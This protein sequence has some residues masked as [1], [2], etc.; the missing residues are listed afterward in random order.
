MNRH[1]DPDRRLIIFKAPPLQLTLTDPDDG[2]PRP[3]AAGMRQPFVPP[4]VDLNGA[5]QAW[6]RDATSGRGSTR[7]TRPG[8]CEENRLAT[9]PVDR[10]RWLRVA[11][12]W[13]S[14][15]RNGRKT[16]T[17][18]FDAVAAERGTKQEQSHSLH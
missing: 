8:A 3:P 14:L 6:R 4:P 11:Q 17:E 1:L 2:C 13:L 7:W 9:S 10:E 15:I 12:G 18:K 5:E 16:E